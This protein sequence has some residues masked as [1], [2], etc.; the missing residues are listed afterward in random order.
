LDITETDGIEMDVLELKLAM[1]EDF[2]VAYLDKRWPSEENN[3][4]YYFIWNR[5]NY[6]ETPF[7]MEGPIE[8]YYGPLRFVGDHLKNIPII[9]DGNL[10]IYDKKRFTSTPH[11]AYKE[12]NLRSKSVLLKTGTIPGFTPP[13]RI[14]RHNDLTISEQI[15]LTDQNRFGSTD[16]IFSSNDT[17]L[18][19]RGFAFTSL[20]VV[21]GCSEN[22]LTILSYHCGS[23]HYFLCVFRITDGKRVH[24]FPVNPESRNHTTDSMKSVMNLG[25]ELGTELQIVKNQMA[26]KGEI[27]GFS[28]QCPDLYILDFE[29]G[30]VIISCKRDLKFENV[31]KFILLD[32]CLVFENSN[33]IILTKFWI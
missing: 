16:W 19:K 3:C 22:Y 24:C 13:I 29:E 17:V 30:D 10:R 6:K 1:D 28:P 14:F 32:D 18:W 33:Q 15:N 20:Q 26:C 27:V 7:K 21:V 25:N 31:K 12:L 5:N 2:L 8:E 9:S 23:Y 11:F 4:C